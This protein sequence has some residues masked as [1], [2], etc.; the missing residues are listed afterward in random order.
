[1]GSFNSYLFCQA[2]AATE[3]WFFL[4]AHFPR[5]R[6]H[7]SRSHNGVTPELLT[8]KL[9][10]LAVSLHFRSIYVVVG[11]NS[12]GNEWVYWLFAHFESSFITFLSTRAHF[13][14]SFSVLGFESKQMIDVSFGI[15]INCFSRGFHAC[16]C[17]SDSMNLFPNGWASN[18]K[19]YDKM[20]KFPVV[21]DVASSFVTFS[22]AFCVLTRCSKSHAN[23]DELLRHILYT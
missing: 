7:F 3:E 12:Q 17:C 20:S 13:F 14:V 18:Q 4:R 2:L 21:P 15:K 11:A 8:W 16:Q 1:M 5:R 23:Y 6:A 10:T 19:S 9:F 22:W